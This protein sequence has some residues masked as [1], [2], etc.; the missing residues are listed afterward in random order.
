MTD[1]ELRRLDRIVVRRAD[2]QAFAFDLLQNLS[3]AGPL[4]DP[5]R[6]R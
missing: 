1:A 3:D 6:K 5:I 2:I 4:H